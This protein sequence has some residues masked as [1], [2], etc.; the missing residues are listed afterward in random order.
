MTLKLPNTIRWENDT[1]YLL[2][3]TKLPLE[4]VEE[5]QE[6]IE[7]IW[8]SIKQLKVR[9]APAIG[10]AGAYGLLYGV[11]D[12]TDLPTDEFLKILK[13]SAEFLNSSRPT[14][15]NLSWA[16]ERMV[17]S[18]SDLKNVSSADIYEKI[19]HEARA[20]HKEDVALCNAIGRFGSVLIEEGMGILTH[21]NGSFGNKRHRYG[22]CPDVCCAYGRKKI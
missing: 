3:Q 21:C 2:D 14:A 8:N 17:A 10:V 12:K 4:V 1:L 20:I 19:V 15:V 6:N 13:E 11:R 22:S 16:L 5:K 9:G 18:A 7:Q